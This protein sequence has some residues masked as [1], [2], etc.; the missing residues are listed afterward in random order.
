MYLCRN[1]KGFFKIIASYICVILL[2]ASLSN[3][4]KNIWSAE[5]SSKGVFLPIIMYHG[6]LK[7]SDYR[8]AY[9][10]TPDT[11]EN[12]M[13]YL[14][15]HG[16]KTVLTE[17]LLK[18]VYNG[19]PLPEKPVMITFD[20]GFYNNIEY[21][22]PLLEKYDMKAIIS[23][24]GYFT[25]TLAENDSHEPAYSY[26]TWDDISQLIAT[27]RIEIGNHTYNMHS[28]TSRRG[29]AKLSYEDN[30][31]YSTALTNDVGLLQSRIYE[32]TGFMPVTFAYPYGYISPESIPV[33]R[34]LGFKATLTCY[35]RPN[36]ITANPDCL[37]GLDR[38]NRPNNMSTEAFMQKLL[39]E[40][41]NNTK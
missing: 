11:L 12:D 31:A 36:Y 10:I 23:I 35:E 25:D 4:T 1:F 29:C 30:E 17:D 6:V 3:L 9:K 2:I 28:N 19:V 38:Y 20:D 24:V 16:Y 33:L 8:D 34:E 15:E 27:G 26:C 5:E 21:A 22:L 14:C 32:K 39:T 40:K 41:P 18:Y 37:Y 7:A 13:K